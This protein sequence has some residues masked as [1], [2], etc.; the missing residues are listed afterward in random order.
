MLVGVVGGATY[1]VA[2]DFTPLSNP[3]ECVDG[4]V[5]AFGCLRL[6]EEMS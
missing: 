3:T 1:L 4:F 6:G 2:A 5:Y